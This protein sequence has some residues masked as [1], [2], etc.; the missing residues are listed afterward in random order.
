MAQYAPDLQLGTNDNQYIIDMFKNRQ[1]DSSIQESP[2][3]S[4]KEQIRESLG[5]AK[6]SA[7]AGGGLGGML[8]SGGLT[9]GMMGAGPVGW[10]VMG[11]GLV[12]SAIEKKRAEEAAREQQ[13]IEN[14]MAKRQNLITLAREA[15]QSNY[16]L[17]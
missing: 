8:T 6:S 3:F 9:A 12:L 16:G 1:E 11:A 15:S 7:A 14:E 4:K 10:G 17:V 5:A 2:E 13:S